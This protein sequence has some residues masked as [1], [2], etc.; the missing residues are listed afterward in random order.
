LVVSEK[1]IFTMTPDKILQRNFSQE[2]HIVSS[3]TH[4]VCSAGR[5][6]G[7]G[8]KICFG[9]GLPENDSH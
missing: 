5:L 9:E 7:A 2:K 3:V 1:A 8:F 6:S 4:F